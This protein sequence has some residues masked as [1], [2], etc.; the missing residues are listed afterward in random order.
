MAT[1]LQSPGVTDALPRVLPRNVQNTPPKVPPRRVKGTLP[2]VPPRSVMVIPPQVQTH[3]RA[4]SRRVCF[5]NPIIQH[6]RLPSRNPASTYFRNPR[7]LEENIIGPPENSNQRR[8]RSYTGGLAT[9][10]SALLHHEEVHTAMR[11]HQIQNLDRLAHHAEQCLAVTHHITRKQMEYRH[12]IQYSFY[13]N[14][15]LLSGAN[16][17]GRLAQGLK[18]GIKGTDTVFFITKQQVPNNQTVT[19]AR[20][21]CSVRPRRTNQTEPGS[22]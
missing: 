13:K 5:A 14:D 6:T 21:V 16:E 22:S 3:S 18:R 4:A 19:Y 8:T 7:I 10:L 20:I 11:N 12:L 15:W 1:L 2:R 17:L 9:A